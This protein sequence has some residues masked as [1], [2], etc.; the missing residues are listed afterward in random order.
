MPDQSI[1]NKTAPDACST[2][3]MP[4]CLL[5]RTLGARVQFPCM[6]E[7]KVLTM[8]FSSKSQR[9]DWFCFLCT[10]YSFG[11]KLWSVF[12]ASFYLFIRR[13][14]GVLRLMIFFFLHSLVTQSSHTLHHSATLQ[15]CTY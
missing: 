7:L 9:S 1:S 4:A 12:P 5:F 14:S 15:Y 3:L 8:T 13:H 11:L 2:S 6:N 10:V